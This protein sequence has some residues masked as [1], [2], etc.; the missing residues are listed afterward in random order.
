MSLS[1]VTNSPLFYLPVIL[2]FVGRIVFYGPTPDRVVAYLEQNGYRQVEVQGPIGGCG[3]G[4]DKFTFTAL[5]PDAG[6]TSG[7]VC[8]GIFG[9]FNSASQDN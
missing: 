7:H 2:F 9:F 5:S 4:N 1:E 3:K 6:R 8:A